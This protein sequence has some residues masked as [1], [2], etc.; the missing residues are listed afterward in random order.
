M[1]LADRLD[2]V[3][4]ASRGEDHP[5]P[6]QVHGPETR[7]PR[8]VD[9][10]APVKQSV[11]QALLDQLGPQLYDPHLDEAELEAKVRHS[12]Q[13]VIDAE[14]TPLS[15]AD[16]TQIAQEVADEILGHGPLEPLLRPASTQ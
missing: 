3:R 7:A 13:A 4:R 14:E 10:F 5:A 6:A 9:P 11:H 8:A 16:R 2:S 12:L 1:S 15:L